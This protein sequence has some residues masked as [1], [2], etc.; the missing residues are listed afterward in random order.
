M[1]KSGALVL[2]IG[3]VS[4]SALAQDATSARVTV[5]TDRAHGT[6]LADGD[7]RAVYMY[8]ED[9][10]GESTCSGECALNWPPFV[11]GSEVT[12]GPGVAA[13]LLGSITRVDGIEQVTYF[14]IPLYYFALDAAPGD[15]IGQGVNDS[16]YLVSPFGSRSF[17]PSRPSRNRCQPKS[18]W[19]KPN[20]QLF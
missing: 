2:F 14:G 17:R 15:A 16:W 3:I 10:K 4:L 5:V 11:A 1:R 8:L 12:A 18:N 20:L 19:Q 7:G 6:H 9:P 13:T